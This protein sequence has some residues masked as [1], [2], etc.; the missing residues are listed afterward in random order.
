M[1]LGEKYEIL[2]KRG[3]FLS[4]VFFN[5]LL[6]RKEERETQI[7]FELANLELKHMYKL[8]RVFKTRMTLLH[9]DIDFDVFN[10]TQPWFNLC[11][12]CL[13]YHLVGCG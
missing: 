6:G 12:R 13:M 7:L 2:S 5:G 11:A 1:E 3:F 4:Y 9:G 8:R 10:T